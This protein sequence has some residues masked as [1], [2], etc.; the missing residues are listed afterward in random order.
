MP[1]SAWLWRPASSWVPLLSR[2]VHLS[3]CLNEGCPSVTEEG[4]TLINAMSMLPNATAGIKMACA[5]LKS[6]LSLDWSAKESHLLRRAF[7]ARREQRQGWLSAA[8]GCWWARFWLWKHPE[9]VLF[10]VPKTKKPKP[11]LNR[12]GP[13][14]FL[15]EMHKMKMEILIELEKSQEMAKGHN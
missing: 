9:V 6:Q 1:G 14:S 12:K 3:S 15:V 11:K 4:D 8:A 7:P 10:F 13:S 2:R 5:N